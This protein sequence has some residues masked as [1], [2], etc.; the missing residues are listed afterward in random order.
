MRIFRLQS[1]AVVLGVALALGWAFTAVQ[2]TA[3]AQAATSGM[4][5]L[6]TDQSGAAIPGVAVT[7]TNA[8]TGAKFTETTNSQGFYRF[9]EIPPGE[10]YTAT[11]SANGFAAMEVKNIYLTVST[12]RTQ[13]ATLQVSAR[14]EKIEVTASNSEVTID[15]TSAQVG[16]TVDVKS[17]NN[18]PVQQRNDPTALFT[19]QPG[20]TDTGA[21]A[22]ARVDQNNVTL[23][24]LDVNDF[25]TGGASQT[26]SGIT[27]GFGSG[28]IVGHAPVDSVEEFHGNVAG[29][30]AATGP[31][32]GGQFQLVT[33]SGTN[34]FHGNLNEY[35]RDPTLVANS[36]FSNNSTPIVPRN[37]LIQNQ[38]GGAIGGPILRDKLFFFF[39][40]NDDRI[41]SSAIQQRVVPLDTLRNGNIGYCTNA[42]TDC[43]TTNFLSPTQVAAFDPAGI[44][45]SST[46]L[47][48]WSARFP[49]ANNSVTGD[50]INTGGY[51]FNAPDN[52]D[53]TNYVTR[54]DYNLSQSMKIFG[55]F[56]ISRENA[57]EA[58]NQFAGDPATDP[59]VDRS[60]AFVV[61]HTWVIGSNKTNQ[62]F[63]GE[64]VQKL[65]FPNTFNP[66]GST[67]F[68]FGDGADS[69]PVPSSLY[70][71]P[72]A[73]ARRI[74]IPMIGDDFSYTKGSHTV[75]LGGTFKDI[76]AHDTT[77]AD[78]NT[79]EIGLGGQTL[80][81]C[82]PTAGSCGTN[83]LGGNNPSLRPAD[84]DP[85]NAAYWDQPF[86]FMLARIANVQSD[87]NFN[88]QGQVL[89][90]LSGDQ[91][92]YRYYQTQLYI[93]DTW[94]VIPSLSVS[95]GLTYQWFTVPY[96]VHG[97][98]SVEPLTF[99]Q[100]MQARVEQSSL[101]ETGN[102]AVPLIA[103]YLG[104]KG[105]GSNAQ[106]LYKPE[107]RNFSPHV[108]FSYNPGFDKKSVFNGSV[109]IVYDRTVINAIQHLQDGYSYLF[110]QTKST[111]S[112]IPQDPY[113]SIA[114]DPRLDKNNGISTVNLTPPATP[115]PPYQP[116]TTNG[117]P[118]GLQ[119]GLAFNETIDPSLKTPYTFIFNAGFQRSLP[120]DMVLKA[121]YVGR[122]GRR[123]LAQAD[124]NQVLEFP[125][126]VSG[127]LYSEAFGNITK[128]IRANPDPTQLQTQPWFENV[129]SPGLG[130][131][132]G[133]ANNTQFLG[134]AIGG[135]V[136]NGDF[137]DFTQAISSIVPPN[138]GMGAQFSENS[139]HNNKG[140]SA[141]N[142]FLLTL[143]KNLSHGV[144]YDFNYTWS[145]SIDNI[146][147]F[148]NSQGDTGIGGGG[149]ICDDIRPR[150]CRAS[151]DFD[152]RHIISADAS[153]ELPFGTGK[154]LFS[155][156]PYWT[157]EV[158]GGWS[159]SGIMDW[160]T[161]YPWQTASNAF[162][163]SYSND[164]P[165]ILVGNPALAK[166]K[167]TKL[168]GGGVSDFADAATASKQYSG[169]VGFQI[170]NRN[171]QRGPG[172]FNTDLGLGKNFPVYG[173]RVSL[174]FRADA[175]NALNHPNF[176]IPTENVF[177]GYDSEDILQRGGFGQIAFTVVP[178]G[179]GNNGA[180]VLQ[181][182]LRLEF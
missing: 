51:A 127:Q 80:G 64:T 53:S 70:L 37:H 116:F 124:A 5:G 33:K 118:F 129:V 94:K 145:H 26:N 134:S 23:D 91:R 93:Q 21:V 131:S 168:P 105:N 78:F 90:Q 22:G 117:V 52:D 120:G 71:N 38:F 29:Q 6:V 151:S 160:H 167:L 166:N 138:V 173:D 111:P 155:T 102:T 14:A 126:P 172:F 139:F 69:A 56:T 123:L 57:Y 103:Y 68:T 130:A 9:S 113:D 88:A 13:N 87:Y 162:V 140:F 179:N 19:L 170:G 100:Y 159:I 47:S 83:A 2:Q 98:E 41:I 39:D 106:G 86:A 150:E 96:E 165:A 181:L 182:S 133:Y 82:G 89:K 112:G 156:V 63:L 174:K 24:G 157:N 72:S 62:A 177:N 95:Y 36:W 28:T 59:L 164:A 108:G 1:L 55:R 158:I 125:D 161:G 25:A 75:Q 163:A 115:K 169:P 4:S 97:L 101:S 141:Y 20:V 142:G 136:K 154:M 12:V 7:L 148:A 171:D 58:A 84:I 48:A 147:F 67:F 149:L 43:S 27:E 49:H 77:I 45:E 11:F 16:I 66:D 119:N 110:Q 79:T 175:F 17:L 99:D 61:G 31:A 32:S 128:E 73:S 54:I 42:S 114:T 46:W 50:G 8:T 137:G 132:L 109:G 176:A 85:G 143:T 15:T 35:H 76:L 60:Y 30:P 40:F 180:R 65:S 81:L 104:G 18:L 122:L 107:Y 152:L 121:S 34:K 144:Q 10:G 135:L 146:S 44:G 74:P 178:S 92:L 153:Y 3:S